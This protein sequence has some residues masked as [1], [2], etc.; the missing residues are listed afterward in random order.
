MPD[1]FILGEKFIGKKRCN[2]F[3]RQFFYGQGLSEN[4]KKC[5]K[6][7]IRSKSFF[8]QSSNPQLFGV[9][10]VNKRNKIL[11]NH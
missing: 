10:K 6:L 7:K 4:L 8:T 11:N 9:A 1:A 5:V 2:D 3:R